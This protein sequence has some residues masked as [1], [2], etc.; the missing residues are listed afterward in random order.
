VQF[1][2]HTHT[3]CLGLPVSR[4]SS[5]LGG[6]CG[7]PPLP[8]PA[9]TPLPHLLP[10]GSRDYHTSSRDACHLGW[11]HR[12]PA[13]LYR[14]AHVLP[15]AHRTT[16]SAAWDS[17]SALH[18]FLLPACCLPATATAHTT[19]HPP[20]LEVQLRLP[21]STYHITDYRWNTVRYITP[22][23]TTT[24]GPDLPPRSIPT[25]TWCRDSPLD[26][27]TPA[28]TTT[29]LGGVQFPAWENFTAPHS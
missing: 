9:T 4:Y 7:S 11:G 21:D 13:H 28:C 6:G 23:F 10:A 8:A 27:I 5:H 25:V 2:R 22:Q 17:C 18:R 16:G 29:C 12:S 1:C 26:T 24:V 15:P 20:A 19:C 3:T 14:F